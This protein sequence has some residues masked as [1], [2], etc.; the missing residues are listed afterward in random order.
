M[1]QL[2]FKPDLDKTLEMWKGFWNGA[3]RR[4][5]ILAILPRPGCRV[6]EPPPYLTAFDCDFHDLAH[7]LLAW[8]ET[9]EFLGDTIP[10]YYLEFGPETF[11]TYLGCDLQLAEDRSTSWSIPFVEDWDRVEIRFRKESY[12]W[13]RTLEAFDILRGHLDGKMMVAAP[14]LLGNLDALSSLRGPQNLLIDLVDHPEQVKRALGQVC[15]AHS[16]ILAALASELDMDRDG[17]MNV[18]GLYYPGRHSRPQ[19]DFSAMISPAIFREFVVPCLESEARDAGAF[20]YHLDG[21]NALCHVPALCGIEKLD[22]IIYAIGA[23]T[24]DRDWT[25]LYDQ[26][27]R[28]GKGQILYQN[29]TPIKVKKAWKK[30]KSRKLAFLPTVTSWGEVEDLIGELEKIEKNI[31]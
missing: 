9:H 12:W 8:A 7:R 17:S 4:P 13:Q 5:I 3:N 24:E 16:E 21:P 27:D 2:E 23:G 18:E 28:L 25:F 29:M 14:A 30:Y 15:Q 19:C 22:I 1:M 11:A 10:N 31:S 6:V 20:T 26:I